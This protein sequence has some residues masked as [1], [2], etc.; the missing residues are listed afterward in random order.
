M[1]KQRLGIIQWLALKMLF[2]KK[3]NHDAV[4]PESLVQT[5]KFPI[6]EMVAHSKPAKSKIAT[7][8]R[9]TMSRKFAS[10]YSELCGV[11]LFRSRNIF[12]RGSSYYLLNPNI[13]SMGVVFTA[14]EFI[15]AMCQGDEA[16]DVYDPEAY[17][18]LT[19]SCRVQMAAAFFTA[20]KLKS[21]ESWM[22]GTNV[23]YFVLCKFVAVYELGSLK[24]SEIAD[25]LLNAELNL[26]AELAVH[27][28]SEFNLHAIVEY[29]LEY[30]LNEKLITPLGACMSM[31]VACFYLHIFRCV[32]QTEFLE[33]AAMNLSGD[34]VA[35]SIVAVAIATL[36][37]SYSVDV[38]NL[39]KLHRI[40]FDCDSL[41]LALEM[42]TMRI[43]CKEYLPN[44]FPILCGLPVA[45]KAQH[46]VEKSIEHWNV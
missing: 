3:C 30:L 39:P 20:Y 19:L 7:R 14:N 24:R 4:S 42:I 40:V 33:T 23:P 9:K 11:S 21:E 35:L 10:V 29:K 12:E 37:S 32:F 5:C 15:R 18:E 38:H 16:E 36:P 13:D 8:V 1:N 27:T 26:L 22:R 43:N 46:L 25:I 44:G 2:K 45:K 28:M 34:C 17:L 31:S 6:H 41:K